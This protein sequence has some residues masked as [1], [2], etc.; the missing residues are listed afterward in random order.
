MR[1]VAVVFLAGIGIVFFLVSLTGC[2]TVYGTAKGTAQNVHS[3]GE[4]VAKDGVG[5]WGAITKADAWMKK[6]MW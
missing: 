1:K 6:N 5:I 4:G 2:N 3:V